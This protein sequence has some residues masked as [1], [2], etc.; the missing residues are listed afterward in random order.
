M[1]SKPVSERRG[2]KISMDLD[3]R[4]IV[5]DV[6]Q[7]AAGSPEHRRHTFQPR[8]HTRTALKIPVRLMTQ[9]KEVSGYTGDIS[10]SGLGVIS[11]AGLQPGTPITLQFSFGKNI[12]HMTVAG[13]VAYCREIGVGVSQECEIGIKFSAI[14]ELEQKILTSAVQELKQDT[15]TQEQSLLTIH[16]AN[17]T[18][19]QEA[20]TLSTK[21]QDSSSVE[22][23]KGRKKRTKFTP[24][25]AWVLELERYN[26]PH[27]RAVLECKLVQEA[28]AGTLP[29]KQMRAWITQLY[30]F[31]ETFPKWIA[32]NITKANDPVSRGFLIDNVRVE[33]RHAEQWV[34]MAEGFGVSAE[35][36]NRVRPLPEVEAL[37]HWLWSIN[38]YGTLAEAVGATTYAV[39]GVTQGIAK[40]TLKG[41]PHYEGL[42][43]VRIDKKTYWWMEAHAKYDDLHPVQ[44]LE[45]MKRYAT[46]RD[47][48]EKVMFAAQRSLEYLLMALEACYTHFQPSAAENVSCSFP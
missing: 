35:E 45:I 23:H 12:C 31:I 43:G 4:R 37:T 5:R 17:D 11:P 18:L 14:R 40:L 19:A 28:S 38:T 39:E 34:Y 10:Q 36:L 42:E 48:Q 32:L 33:K 16:V 46:T 26:A 1:S 13:R 27:F 15:A 30:P 9:E 29:L 8:C 41:F 24:H 21:A 44:A 20:A 22:I 2:K 47:L 6:S 3:D 7:V 25:P